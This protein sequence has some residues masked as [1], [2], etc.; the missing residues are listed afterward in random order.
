[1]PADS[2][3]CG[4]VATSVDPQTAPTLALADH[5]GVRVEALFSLTAFD[6]ANVGEHVDVG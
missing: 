5:F 6:G 2:G 4:R 3:H 1:M